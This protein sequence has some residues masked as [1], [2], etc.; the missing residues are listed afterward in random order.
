MWAL[1][2][3]IAR[4]LKLSP[5]GAG[6]LLTLFHEEFSTKGRANRQKLLAWS[7]TWRSSRVT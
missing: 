1:T 4:D 7:G 3:A 6:T 2:D 5:D